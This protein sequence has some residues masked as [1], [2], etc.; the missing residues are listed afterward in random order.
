MRL[1][2]KCFA[3]CLIMILL[4]GCGTSQETQ[5][6]VDLV[7]TQVAIILTETAMHQPQ[8]PTETVAPTPTEQQIEPT[9]TP[10][11][12]ATMTL[13]PTATVTQ[14]QAPSDPAVLLGAPAWTYEFIGSNSPWDYESDQA[15]FETANGSLNISA[16]LSPNWHS[17]WV[18]SPKLKDAY[19]EATIKMGTCSGFDRFGLIIRASSDGEQFYLM[20]LTCDGRWGFFRMAPDVDFVTIKD[21]Q[22]L[23]GWSDAWTV[24]HRIGVWMDGATFQLYIDGEQV[25][26]V[27]DNTLSG[28]G[29][30]GFMIAFSDTP[31]FTVH[32]D[33]LQYWDVP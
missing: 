18:S 15:V 28:E 17:W 9:Y 19:V 14:T 21:Y 16:L 23:E 25:G 13:T 32:V 3:F 1:R 6:S 12:T 33:Q 24:A 30:T 29:Y 26:M 4:A 8:D 27:S 11:E 22:P 20:D 2:Q 5:P 31:G 7:A 10:T